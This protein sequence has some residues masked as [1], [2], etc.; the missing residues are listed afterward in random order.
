M[1][2]FN[3]EKAKKNVEEFPEKTHR[4][5][6][7]EI[8]AEIENASLKGKSFFNLYF[9]D[10]EKYCCKDYDVREL[11]ALQKL[12]FTIKLIEKEWVEYPLYPFMWIWKN[13]TGTFHVVSW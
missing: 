2:E 10:G 6:F 5:R 12:G 1:N 13:R 7:F 11:T 8:L 9:S 4:L 3:A